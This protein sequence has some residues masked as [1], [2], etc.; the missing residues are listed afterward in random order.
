MERNVR[1]SCG[2]S[3]PR[4][5]PQALIAARADLPRKSSALRSNQ[6]SNF[7]HLKKTVDKLNYYRVCL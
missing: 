4:E 3:G 6:W 1:D 5:T 7:K 2:K